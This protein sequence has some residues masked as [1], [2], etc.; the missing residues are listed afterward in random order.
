MQVNGKISTLPGKVLL[1]EFLAK[2]GY[3]IPQI[4]IEL[5]GKIIA[6]NE[7]EKVYLQDD[8]TL[9]IVTFMGGGQDRLLEKI[10]KAAAK[11]P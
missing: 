9:E 1:T 10:C 6:K 11:Q 5:N 8:D 7:Y 4:A 2:E 3:E